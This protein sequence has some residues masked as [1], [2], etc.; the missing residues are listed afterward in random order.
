MKINGKEYSVSKNY[1]ELM[2]NTE[3]NPDGRL[4]DVHLNVTTVDDMTTIVEKMIHVSYDRDGLQ[5]Y[6]VKIGDKIAHYSPSETVKEVIKFYN[7][8]KNDLA[9]LK[10]DKDVDVKTMTEEIFENIENV[11][12]GNEKTLQETVVDMSK[13]TTTGTIKTTTCRL[14][15]RDDETKYVLDKINVFEYKYYDG[16]SEDKIEISGEIR[17]PYD[18]IYFEADKDCNFTEIEAESRKG[19]ET[20][21]DLLLSLKCSDDE[22]KLEIMLSDVEPNEREE[23]KN[24]IYEIKDVSELVVSLVEMKEDLES[25]EDLTEKEYPIEDFE[26]LDKYDSFEC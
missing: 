8:E 6:S 21:K 24:I 18:T 15:T 22:M 7:N 20:Y 2:R 10:N 14:E 19:Y 5:L 23:I 12:R 1:T 11:I 4:V 25:K 9:I 16:K 17:A 13:M 26:T 3:I